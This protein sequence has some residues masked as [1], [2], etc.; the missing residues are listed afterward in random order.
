MVSVAVDGASEDEQ[1]RIGWLGDIMRHWHL[2]M[3]DGRGLRWPDV[4]RGPAPGAS[5]R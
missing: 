3:A 2:S 4:R 5:T 1:P